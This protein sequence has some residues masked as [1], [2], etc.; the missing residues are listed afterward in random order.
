[1]QIAVV[2]RPG[3]PDA[4]WERESVV[5]N[6]GEVW[7]VGG[8]ECLGAVRTLDELARFGGLMETGL[9]IDHKLSGFQHGHQTV[10]HIRLKE[11]RRARP[12]EHQRS[13]ELALIE[14]C[15]Q[16]HSLCTV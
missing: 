12:L 15:T 4:L 10:R 3:F 13:N 6:R 9:I 5:F 8:Q 11:R 16:T 14:G 7:G 1:M 2:E